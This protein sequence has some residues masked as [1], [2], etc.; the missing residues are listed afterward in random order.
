[1]KYSEIVHLHEKEFKMQHIYL[2]NGKGLKMDTGFWSY[3]FQS[4]KQEFSLNT[5]IALC[6]SLELFL[7]E[8]SDLIL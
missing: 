5:V 3:V 6:C 7:S 1:M 4:I 2:S 8:F